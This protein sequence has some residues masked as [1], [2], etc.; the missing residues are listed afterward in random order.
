MSI[1]APIQSSAEDKAIP[2]F[3]LA[4]LIYRYSKLGSSAS[5][6]AELSGKILSIAES[7]TAGALYTSLCDRFG[8]SIDTDK[9][10]D[11]R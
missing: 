2:N 9:I 3:E 7:E 10:S 5:I 1:S 4:Q 11:I 8:W 6:N